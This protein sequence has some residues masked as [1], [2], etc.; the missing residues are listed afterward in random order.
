MSWKNTLQNTLLSIFAVMTTSCSSSYLPNVDA[1]VSDGK[2]NPPTDVQAAD[3]SSLCAGYQIEKDQRM[4]NNIPL[5]PLD[6]VVAHT[7]Q[8]SLR[9]LAVLPNGIAWSETDV[10][11]GKIS[12]EMIRSRDDSCPIQEIVTYG[13]DQRGNSSIRA[14]ESSGTKLVFGVQGKESK[15]WVYDSLTTTLQ[16]TPLEDFI[17][18]NGQQLVTWKRYSFTEETAQRFVVYTI[19]TGET[20]ERCHVPSNFSE[21]E[22]HYLPDPQFP[23]NFYKPY[24]SISGEKLY[25][26]LYHQDFGGPRV[27][28]ECN[29]DTGERRTIVSDVRIREIKAS[30]NVLAYI[31]AIDDHSDYGALRLWSLRQNE[32]LTLPKPYPPSIFAYPGLVFSENNL[33]MQACETALLGVSRYCEDNEKYSAEPAVYALNLEN[34]LL[35]QVTPMGQLMELESRNRSIRYTLFTANNSIAYVRRDALSPPPMIEETNSVHLCQLGD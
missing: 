21:T 9:N 33:F 16:Q 2:L 8:Q 32:Q 17:A 14:F 15:T 34:L 35:T 27:I 24:F 29:L 13:P 22:H 3:S 1:G 6:C 5:A 25:Y 12:W 20:V 4:T 31:T 10:P 28:E 18:F 7:T 30:E 26:V 11:Y 19:E 23:W